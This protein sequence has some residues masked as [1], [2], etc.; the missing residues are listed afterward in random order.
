MEQLMRAGIRDCTF[1]TCI[2]HTASTLRVIIIDKIGA[3]CLK[4]RACVCVCRRHTSSGAS[5]GLT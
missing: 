3:E 5:C 1:D 2:L 4:C